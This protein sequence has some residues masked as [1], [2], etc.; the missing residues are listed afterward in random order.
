MNFQNSIQRGKP[1]NFV[2]A[3]RYYQFNRSRA[4]RDVFDALVEILTNSDDSY[5]RLYIKQ[6]RAE[7]GGP[8][9]IEIQ[10]QRKG[11]PSTIIIRDRA[12]GMT[13]DV[14]RKKLKTIGERTSEESD[15]GFMAR[16]LRDCTELGNIIIESIV[17][18]KY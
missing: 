12:E 17:D 4:I 5:H 18:K 11:S 6:K 8:I 1:E 9:L 3:D 15:R 7:D 10:E 13:L 16:G 14:M 2:I